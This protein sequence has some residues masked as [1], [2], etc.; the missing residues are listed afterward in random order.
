MT[1]MAARLRAWNTTLDDAVDVRALAVLRIAIGP[2]VLLHLRPFL[3]AARDGIIYSDRFTLPFWDWYPEL[4]RTAYV[5]LLW[6]IVATA[7]VHPDKKLASVKPSSVTKRM[8]KK[9]FARNVSREIIMECEKLVPTLEEFVEISLAAMQGI[10]E[11]LG[12]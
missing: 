5:I 11:E 6:L 1:T 4:P 8:K 10:A 2:V 12:L 7:L 9:D 3:T